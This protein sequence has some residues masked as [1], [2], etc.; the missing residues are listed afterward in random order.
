MNRRLFLAAALGSFAAPLLAQLPPPPITRWR[1]RE[2]EGLD[3][4]A[5]LGALSGGSL[6]LDAYGA[7]AAVFSPKLPA[8]VRTDL[9]ALARES[10]ADQF[11]LLW[12][13]LANLMSGADLSTLDDVIAALR[14]PE[15]RVRP[16][17][18]A[19][20]YWDAK[21]W[22]WFVAAA[23]RL[24]TVFAAMRDAGFADFRRARIGAGLA[25]RMGEIERGLADYDVIRWQRKLT[26]R[27]YAPEIDI[28]LLHFSKPHGVRVQGQ[29]FLQAADY[30]IATTVRIAA[31]EVLHPPIRMD[32]PVAK[33]AMALLEK[34]A[35]I[36]RI[37]REHDPRWGY[38]TL[39]G[40]LNEDLCQALDQLISEALGVGRNPADRWRKVDDGMHVLAAGLYGLLRQDCW[41]EAGGSIETW[42]A[43]AIETGR[44]APATLHATAAR[45][46]E[47]PADRLWPL[48]SSAPAS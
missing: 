41:V 35:L 16:A 42:L 40:Y 26:G 47:R 19:S 2:S 30:T 39:E 21:D 11:G 31:H 1:V 25:Q 36:T 48:A 29:T 46:L 3:A 34:D 7:E 33:T 6:Y 22:S 20:Q 18:Q 38:T 5:F 24:I 9:A 28:V 15:A 8:A 32:G 43:Q 44:L 27:D 4:V 10:E 17:Y 14:E 12:P 45:V 37:V 23:P 13:G